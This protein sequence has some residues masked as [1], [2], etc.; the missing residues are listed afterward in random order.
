[1]Q[2]LSKVSEYLSAGT[3]FMGVLLGFSIFAELLFGKFLGNV[4]VVGN[5]TE[6]VSK[7]GDNGFVGLLAMML[8]VGF[9]NKDK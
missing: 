1:M 9:I 4:S 8:I 5:I 6:I 3:K 7:F 2:I